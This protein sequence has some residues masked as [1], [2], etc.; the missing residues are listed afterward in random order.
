MNFCSAKKRTLQSFV[1]KKADT[2]NI[3][4]QKKRTLQSLGGEHYKIVYWTLKNYIT[5]ITKLWTLQI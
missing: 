3:C 4:S 5:D 1:M 2:A